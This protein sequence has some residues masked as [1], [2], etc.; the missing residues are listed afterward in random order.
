MLNELKRM[1]EALAAIRMLAPWSLEELAHLT[2]IPRYRLKAIEYGRP[3]GKTEYLAVRVII[4]ETIYSSEKDS[5]FPAAVR[6]LLD[7]YETGSDGEDIKNVVVNM[8]TATAAT[9]ASASDGMT[10]ALKKL[11]EALPADQACKDSGEN[12]YTWIKALAASKTRGIFGEY[13]EYEDAG[14][15]LEPITKIPRKYE[16]IHDALTEL[17]LA[18]IDIDKISGILDQKKLSEDDYTICKHIFE[19][20]IDFWQIKKVPKNGTQELA[21]LKLILE[22]K[23]PPHSAALLKLALLCGERFQEYQISSGKGQ[24]NYFY[25]KLKTAFKKYTTI[26]I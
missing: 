22:Q 24:K 15:A 21:E 26:E 2:G 19:D 3:M 6:L 14:F 11:F 8:L 7:E 13:G 23:K 17:G 10:D 1:G 12:P 9:G 20:V 16:E 25:P 18:N 4:E 5:I